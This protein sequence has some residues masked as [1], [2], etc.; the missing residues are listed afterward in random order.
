[1][2]PHVKMCSFDARNPGTQEV[3]H[4][5]H[6]H[7]GNVFATANFTSILI[8]M[9]GKPGNRRERPL[10]VEFLRTEYNPLD[11]VENVERGRPRR[12]SPQVKAVGLQPPL[13]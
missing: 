11:V 5:L 8:V 9:T 10:H 4:L 13:V 7:G 1:M 12:R 3:E 6:A 2:S